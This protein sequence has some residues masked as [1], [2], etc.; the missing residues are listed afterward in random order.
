MGGSVNLCW[1]MRVCVLS[2]WL[3]VCEHVTMHLC[4]R[5]QVFASGDTSVITSFP[6][7]CVFH[8]TFAAA[9]FADL[10]FPLS[11]REI[12]KLYSLQ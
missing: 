4:Q 1:S 10:F 2:V 11:V 7:S 12:R 8:L 9:Y 5:I 3:P 6:S